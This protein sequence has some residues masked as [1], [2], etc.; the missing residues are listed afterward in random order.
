[1]KRFSR[2]SLT[3]MAVCLLFI[4]AL[5][6]AQPRPAHRKKVG[7]VL[8][9]GGAKGMAHIGVLKVIEKAGIPIDYVVGTSMGSIIGGLYSIGYSPE[10]LDSMVRRQ[11]WTFLLSD[12]IPRSE[13]N[14]SE[15]DASQK[16]VFSIPFGKG[17]KAEVFGGLIRGQNLANLF[18]E[19]TIGYHDSINFNKLPIPFAC[20]SENIVNGNE[21]NFH[22]GVLATAMRASMAIPGVFTPVRLD[23][24]VLVDGGVV[25]NYPVNVA[26]AMGAD[27]I[28]G[29]DVQSE[30][31]PAGELNSAGAILGQLVNLMGQDLYKKNLKETTTYI[32]V[33]VE[34]YSAASFT[35]SAIDTLIMRGEEA[36]MAQDSALMA[37]KSQLGLDSTYM[38]QPIPSYPY[39]PERKVYIWRYGCRGSY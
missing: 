4:P 8:S 31:K 28:I 34:G 3:T 11:D 5:L 17:V 15:R 20:V 32:K 39:S 37:L 21:V 18:S 13:Q 35:P 29:V 7:V 27:L 19:L 2:S 24:M 6:K 36:A 22:E 1:M 10:Q 38:P 14:L 9:G 33:N 12:K 16:Y 26:R 25:N 30:L 23:S